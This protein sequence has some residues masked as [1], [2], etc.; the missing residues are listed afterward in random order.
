[1]CA[2]AYFIGSG[3]RTCTTCCVVCLSIYDIKETFL[4]VI[5]HVPFHISA[6][7]FIINYLNVLIPC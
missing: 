2:A 3:G 4:L 7:I 5:K 6:H 1:M